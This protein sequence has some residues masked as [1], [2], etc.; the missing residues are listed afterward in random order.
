MDNWGLTLNGGPNHIGTCHNCDEPNGSV[1]DGLCEHC[2]SMQPRQCP[3]CGCGYD[4]TEIT[5][6]GICN[7]CLDLETE[8][9]ETVNETTILERIKFRIKE[10]EKFSMNLIKAIL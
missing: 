2:Q 10:E 6:H 7:Y 5:E 4:W 9:L 1:H 8:M 3:L